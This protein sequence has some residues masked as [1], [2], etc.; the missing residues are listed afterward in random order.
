[1]AE[2]RWGA[3]GTPGEVPE[4]N[5]LHPRPHEP[6]LRVLDPRPDASRELLGS[7]SRILGPEKHRAWRPEE[8]RKHVDRT[9]IV[10]FPALLPTCLS[11]NPQIKELCW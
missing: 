9:V 3:G 6:A 11:T 2:A 4:T 5:G 10:T 1:M 8:T 7:S